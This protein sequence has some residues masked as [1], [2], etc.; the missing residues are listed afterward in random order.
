MNR[1]VPFSLK[2][3]LTIV[4]LL[5][6]LAGQAQN[7]HGVFPTIDHSGTISNKISYS[8]Y[9]FIGANLINEKVNN[10]RPP[11][12]VYFLYTE[13]ALSYNII[14]QLSVTGSYVY[15]R[16]RPFGDDFR[17]EHRFYLQGTYK[18]DVGKTTVKH[19]LR[20]DGRFIQNRITGESPYTSRLRYL[21]G[22]SFPLKKNSD[23]Y[24]F[25][26]YN[27]FFFNTFRAS[28]TLYAENWAY[29]GAGIKTKKAGSFEAGPLYIFWVNKAA[30]NDLTNFIYLQC[31][32]STHIDLRKK[33]AK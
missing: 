15:E 17:N 31:T 21:T 13:Q 32:W 25:S 6:T 5:H 8:L 20:Y 28:E 33:T 16:L 11:A 29:A 18:Y 12:N 4:L 2:Y 24:Y 23:K 7:Y 14:P 27:E 30:I 10:V 9:Y 26:A 1:C 3:L 19:R 22:L